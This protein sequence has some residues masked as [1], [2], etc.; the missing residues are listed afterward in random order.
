MKENPNSARITVQMPPAEKAYFEEIA[1]ASG[2]SISAEALQRLR[3][4]YTFEP[5]A[6]TPRRTKKK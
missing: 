5:A 1:V 3:Q 6:K 2:R 4:T